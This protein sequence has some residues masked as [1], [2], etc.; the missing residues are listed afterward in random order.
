MGDKP[1]VFSSLEGRG[2]ARGTALGKTM[3]PRSRKGSVPSPL[4]LR[5]SLSLLHAAQIPA[6]ETGKEHSEP[7]ITNTTQPFPQLT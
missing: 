6:P 3:S 4:H 2:R 1:A 7:F 5:V